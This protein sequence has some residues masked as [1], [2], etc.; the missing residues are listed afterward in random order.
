M[1]RI[2]LQNN[3]MA[4]PFL[5]TASKYPA[6][7]MRTAFT[8]AAITIILPMIVIVLAGLLIGF[9]VFFVLSIIARI[10]QL[11]GLEPA[12]Q[13]GTSAPEQP[14]SDGRDNVRVMDGD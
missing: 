11:L 14:V 13:H 12:S 3:R 6:W 10:M 1:W 9:T 7:V 5:A 8:A 2:L 4:Q